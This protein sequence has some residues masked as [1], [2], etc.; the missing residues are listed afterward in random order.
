MI[1]PNSDSENLSMA[2]YPRK[3]PKASTDFE[4]N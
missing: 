4:E 3:D 1:D 2:Q